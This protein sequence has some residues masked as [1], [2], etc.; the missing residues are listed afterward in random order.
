MCSLINLGLSIAQ[1]GV[2]SKFLNEE[3]MDEI[4]QESSSQP[5]IVKLRN[6]LAKLGIYQVQF[7]MFFYFTHLLLHMNINNNVKLEWSVCIYC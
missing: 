5:C 3:V 2:I 6:G 7:G 1:N 4:F